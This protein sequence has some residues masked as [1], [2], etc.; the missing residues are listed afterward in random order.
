MTATKSR[1]HNDSNV[2]CLGS[3]ISSELEA[4]EIVEI[5][6]NEK[7]GEGRHG[8]RVHMIDR[9]KTGVVMANG[10]FDLLHR[11]H[12]ELLNFA[13]A[14]GERL[15]VAIDNDD[16][17]RERKGLSRPVNT[18]KDRKALLDSLYMVDEVIIFDTPEELKQLYVK[19]KADV[20]VKG[21]EWTVDEVRSR[22]DIPKEIDIKVFPLFD[23]LSSTRSIEKIKNL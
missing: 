6:I 11:G 23:E 7:W 3:W 8:R 19:V 1:D 14:Q 4:K 18:A 12:I 9:E 15:V 5:W 2:L 20:I 22:D 17:V 16:L 21:S 10:V 13:K